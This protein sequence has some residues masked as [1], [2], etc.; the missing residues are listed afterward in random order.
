MVCHANSWGT[1]DDT[2][3]VKS[4]STAQNQDF[5]RREDWLDQRSRDDRQPPLH[6]GT[7]GYKDDYHVIVGRGKLTFLCRGFPVCKSRYRPPG[8]MR[9]R[10]PLPNRRKVLSILTFDLEDTGRRC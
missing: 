7:S 4:L 10:T 1:S 6:R 5:S 8:L 2:A 3:S 9:D